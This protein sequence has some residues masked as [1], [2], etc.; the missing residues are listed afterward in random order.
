MTHQGNKSRLIPYTK[1]HNL[2]FLYLKIFEFIKKNDIHLL[3]KNTILTTS[4]SQTLNQKTFP[5]MISSLF[6]S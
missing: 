3:I 4:C 6:T 2:S 5:L 1:L